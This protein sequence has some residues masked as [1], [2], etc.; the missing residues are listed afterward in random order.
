MLPKK[1]R[2]T[3]ID[4]LRQMVMK[5][6][7]DS[8]GFPKIVGNIVVS[9]TTGENIPELREMVYSKAM[10]A[11][12]QGESVIGKQVSLYLKYCKTCTSGY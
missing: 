2:E 3:R 10:K 9:A 4:K 5:K 1:T 12:E 8:K 11:K 6:Y 7:A